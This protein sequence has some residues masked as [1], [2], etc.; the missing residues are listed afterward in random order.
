MPAEEHLQYTPQ[1]PGV[2]LRVAV[3]A[4]TASVVLLAVV[5]SVLYEIYNVSVPVKTVPA[6]RSF[7]QP[8]V[9]TDAADVAQL[10]RVNAEQA[11]RLNSWR[12]ADAKHTLVQV[13]VARAMQLLVAKGDNAW[14]PLETAPR[15]PVSPSAQNAA[16]PQEKL[17]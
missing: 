11:R 6:P 16:S 1:P 15:A 9:V 5:I 8:Q 2:P 12:W 13:P 7:P 4:A 10:H 17:Q 3:G 14:A